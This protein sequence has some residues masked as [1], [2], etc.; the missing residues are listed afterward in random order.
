VEF[1]DAVQ[2]ALETNGEEIAEILLVVWKENGI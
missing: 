2:F 1:V